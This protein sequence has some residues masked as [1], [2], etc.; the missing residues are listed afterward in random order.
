M[1]L[2][3]WADIARTGLA[4]AALLERAADAA[5]FVALFE[6]VAFVVEFFAFAHGEAQFDKTAA[7]KQF[8]RHNGAALVFGVGKGGDFA[9]FGQQFAVADLLAFGN[10]DAA[11]AVDGAVNEPQFAVMD[12]HVR[13]AE[14]AVAHAQGFGF[15]AGKGNAN[16]QA[17]A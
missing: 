5:L 11:S 7:G 1:A 12:T 14:L 4:L 8:E 9:L 17:V 10:G 13:A 15:A 6:G 16:D 2:Q 3:P